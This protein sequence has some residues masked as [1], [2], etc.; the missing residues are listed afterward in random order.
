[1]S[2]HVHAVAVGMS[3]LL[4]LLP[5]QPLPHL[6]HLLHQPHLLQHLLWQMHCQKA[7]G[8]GVAMV[9]LLWLWVQAAVAAVLLLLQQ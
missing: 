3:I 5:L 7:A 1:M 9:A 2:V 8:E 6:M 4:C